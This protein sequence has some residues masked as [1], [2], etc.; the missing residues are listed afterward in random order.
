MGKPESL[1]KPSRAGFIGRLVTLE[2]SKDDLVLMNLFI[3]C[4]SF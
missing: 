4:L 2:F 3:S 1:A